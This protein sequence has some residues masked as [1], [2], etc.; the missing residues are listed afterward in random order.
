M[1]TRSQTSFRPTHL[2]AFIAFVAVLLT[3]IAACGSDQMAGIEGSGSPVASD[4]T[5]TGRI[6]GFGSIFIDGVEYDTATAQIRI[7]DQPATEA[8]LRVGHVVKVIGTLAPDGKKGT[9]KQVTLTSDVRGDVASVDITANTFV[10]LGQTVKVTADTLFDENIQAQDLAGLKSG[11][12]VRV[13]GFTSATGEVLAS[14]VDG[15]STAAVD[16]QVSGKVK[17]LDATAKSFRVNNLVVDYRSATVSGSLAEGSDA[18]VHGTTA[19]DGS[20]VAT[21]ITV[22]TQET[23]T[24]GEKGQLEGLITTFDSTSSFIVEGQKVSTNASTKFNLHGL[25]LGTDIFV[26]V[27]GT[28]DSSRV[29]VADQVEAKPTAASLVRGPVDAISVAAGTVRV[30]GVTAQTSASTTFEDKGADKKRQFKLGDVAVGD[31]LEV[32]GVAAAGEPLIASSVQRSK[33]EDRS[34]LQG[35]AQEIARPAFKVL[36]VSVVTDSKTSFPGLGDGTKGA[37]AFFEQAANQVVSVRGTM[38]GGTLLADQVR[39]VS[40]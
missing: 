18:T 3:L 24:T 37:D 19:P 27:K 20:L 29:L 26:K 8:D 33:G 17:N 16:V 6:N 1:D 39:I 14:R 35:V 4:V 21:Q 38:N 23:V 9:A 32:R 31:Y 7:D 5:T 2:G 12:K 10:V 30:L 34:Y 40:K 36:G 11:V 15:V 25:T 13:S 22:D 28:F